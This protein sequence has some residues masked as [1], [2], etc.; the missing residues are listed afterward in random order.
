M[1]TSPA[2]ASLNVDDR[3]QSRLYSMLFNAEPASLIRQLAIADPPLLVLLR[4][5]APAVP[6]PFGVGAGSS[7]TVHAEI[8]RLTE[9]GLVTE[10]E[11]GTT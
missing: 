1:S 9:A 6:Q 2:S 4:T 3:P 5:L 10:K 7:N 8:A 11:I